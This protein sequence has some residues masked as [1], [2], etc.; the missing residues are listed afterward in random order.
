M[1]LSGSQS[2]AASGAATL[3]PAAG[4]GPS[5][6]GFPEPPQGA[7]FRVVKAEHDVCGHATRV[8]LPAHLPA[9]AV[10]RVVCAA[11]ATPFEALSVEEVE[12]VAPGPE[13]T[14]ARPGRWAP[15]ATDGG[16]TT[17]AP[18]RR[19]L[20]LKRPA[21][22]RPSLPGW[23][24]EPAS[25]GF[26][27]ATIPLA[28]AAVIGALLLIQGGSE[29]P[30][31][32]FAGAVPEAASPQGK[33]RGG[34]GAKASKADGASLVRESSFSL[35]L[36]AGWE[37]TSPS[38]GSTFAAVSASGDADATLWVER[39]PGLEFAAFEARSM[40]QLEALAGS[41]R[42]VERVTAPT[43]EASVVRLAADAP[44]GSP[45]YEVTL[46]SAGPYRY[47]LATTVQPDASDEAVSGA[48]LIHGSFVPIGG[49]G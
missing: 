20:T 38:G 44:A 14:R 47:Y 45:A 23:A 2:G 21:L 3:A 10:R 1:D 41:A 22:P 11:C 28:A 16:V 18:V 42:V 27:L 49:E 39:D 30:D 31:T 48:K 37:R 19:R 29:E 13:A 17:G 35:A 7:L 12:L 26:K 40:D 4:D 32:P 25:T 8:R 24:R 9:S 43:P 6:G 34:D 36:P 46:R 33:A 5:N 15:A